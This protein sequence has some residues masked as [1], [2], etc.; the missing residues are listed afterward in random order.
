MCVHFEALAL[1]VYIDYSEDGL[2]PYTGEWISLQ[3]KETAQHK[4]KL[5]KP[6]E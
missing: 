6:E 5:G 1:E 4:Q 2:L 3:Q